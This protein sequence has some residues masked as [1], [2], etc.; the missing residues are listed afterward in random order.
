MNKILSFSLFI[1]AGASFAFLNGRC[2]SVL[3]GTVI[4]KILTSQ[5]ILGAVS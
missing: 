4:S 5:V 2:F 1:A 3:L